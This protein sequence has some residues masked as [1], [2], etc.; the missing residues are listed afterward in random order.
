MRSASIGLPQRRNRVPPKLQAVGQSGS[1]SAFRR[2]QA[3]RVYR[4]EA[5]HNPEVAGSNPAPATAKG[6]GDGAFCYL[7]SDAVSRSTGGFCG[8][9]SA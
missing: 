6:A 1:E 9:R 4:I 2:N 3:E 8:R 7:A 5:A